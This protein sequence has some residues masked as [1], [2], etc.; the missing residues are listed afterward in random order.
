MP[1]REP[2]PVRR[3]RLNAKRTLRLRVSSHPNPA[4]PDLVDLTIYNS[5]GNYGYNVAMTRDETQ[6]LAS[7]LQAAAWGP[8]DA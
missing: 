1:E 2:L 5:I 7:A 3:N 8:P 4:E 6:A